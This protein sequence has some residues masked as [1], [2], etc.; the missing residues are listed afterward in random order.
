MEDLDFREVENLL[1]EAVNTLPAQRRKVYQLVRE[2]G[3]SYAEI[4]EKLQISKNTVRN[5]VAEALQEIRIYL[6]EH[7][8]MIVFLLRMVEK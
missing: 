6:R 4:A 8:V 2:E 3:L 7:G 1:K 5:H